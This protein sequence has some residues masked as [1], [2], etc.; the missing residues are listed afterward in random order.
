MCPHSHEHLAALSTSTNSKL[1]LVGPVPNC[2]PEDPISHAAYA[3]ASQHLH[4]AILS[5]SLRVWIYARAYAEDE[6]EHKHEHEHESSSR[7]SLPL[8]FLFTACILHDLGTTPAFSHID[9]EPDEL[10]RFEIEGA[11]AAASLLREFRS[12]ASGGDGDSSN[13]E[14]ELSISNEDID[15]VWRAIA[16]HTTPQIAERMGGMV[17]VVRLAV[18][19]DFNRGSIAGQ[20]RLQR[21]TEAE[22]ERMDIER[23]LVDAVVQQALS[24]RMPEGKAPPASWPHDLLRAHRRD[25]RWKG[26]NQGF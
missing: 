17:R 5:H 2:V 18:L 10:Q 20:R 21:E 15:H 26:V 12:R 13:P 9:S 7:L 11:D 19:S 24:S 3:L 14:Q 22:F 8:P 23:V 16:L 6:D 1:E 4:P 25:S